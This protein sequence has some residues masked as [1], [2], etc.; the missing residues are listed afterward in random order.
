MKHKL[1]FLVLLLI[2]FNIRQSAAQKVTQV[3]KVD[4]V[5]IDFL[6]GGDIYKATDTA[7]L[8]STA[9]AHKQRKVKT[10]RPAK[11]VKGQATVK[12]YH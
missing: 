12:P 1:F 10:T 6:P 7:V 8:K 5:G 2:L 4:T 3:K 11:P 9:K